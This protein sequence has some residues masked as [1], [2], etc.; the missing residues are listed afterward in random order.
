MPGRT[1][2]GDG[3]PSP[4]LPSTSCRLEA[5]NY[6]H[7]L[8]AMDSTGR[9]RHGPMSTHPPVCSV[10]CHDMMAKTHLAPPHSVLHHCSGARWAGYLPKQLLQNRSKQNVTLL[11][12]ARH[13]FPSAFLSTKAWENHFMFS[14]FSLQVTASWEQFQPYLRGEQR[15][16]FAG[17]KALCKSEWNYTRTIYK[18]INSGIS[19]PIWRTE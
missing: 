9:A 2:T 13:C 15:I 3:M 14:P 8:K 18:K 17:Q 4:L 12:G 6:R 5:V 7:I 16:S 10:P 1:Q 19:F 11:R